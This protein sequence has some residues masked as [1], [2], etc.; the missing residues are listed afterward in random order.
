[1]KKSIQR[2]GLVLSAII[3]GILLVW[4]LTKMGEKSTGPLEDTMIAMGK[5]V[6]S[7]ENKFILQNRKHTR[8]ESL[9]WFN[10]YRNDANKMANYE[11]IF[12]GAFDNE[13][14]ESF[15]SIVELENALQTTFPIIHIYTA[16]GSKPEQRFPAMQAKAILD[17][18]SIPCITWEPWLT[19]FSKDELPNI[20]TDVKKRDKHGL[21]AIANGDY[22]IYIDKWAD[23]VKALGKLIFV[24]LGHEMNDPYRYPWG[25]QNNK[26]E[27]FVAAW[28]HVVNRFRSTGA[29]NAI[30][31]WSPHPAYSYFDYY[32]PGD[33]FVDWVGIGALNYGNVAT[34]GK[35]WTFDEIFG[36]YYAQLSK[37]KKPIMISEFGSLDVGGNRAKW[38]G[39]AL[40]S[41]P[42]KY[43]AIKAVIFFHCSNDNTTTSKALN[44]YFKDDSL[45]TQT[46]IQ[47]IMQG[48]PNIQKDSFKK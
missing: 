47:S 19:D 21:R 37:Y 4:F 10:E 39:D 7:I 26:P 40:S 6:S 29:T 18:G 14:S 46:I 11:H 32:Y 30:W 28:K 31:V 22:D 25:P 23:E 20:V 9:L 24:R 48:N 3:S 35:W 42:V 36:N 13:F 16:W 12:Y 17:V 2:I 1:M 33:E 41:M 44:W 27:D 43:P 15:Q 34:W 38:F 8:S 45:I 5:G